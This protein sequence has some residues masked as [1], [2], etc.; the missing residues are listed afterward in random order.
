LRQVDSGVD[1]LVVSNT[2]DGAEAF[3][4]AWSPDGAK[5]YYLARSPKG[6]S[7]R[8]VPAA[9]GAS[10]VLVNFDDPGRQQI[11]YGFCTDGKVFYFTIGSPESDIYVADLE[12]P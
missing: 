10:T 8:S 2:R 7:I 6:W 1:T 9:G 5:I 11:R 12:Q 4:T 3:Y